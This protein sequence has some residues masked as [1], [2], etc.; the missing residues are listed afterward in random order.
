MDFTSMK[1]DLPGAVLFPDS[2]VGI[3]A[4]PQGVQLLPDAKFSEKPLRLRG[5][6]DHAWIKLRDVYWAGLRLRP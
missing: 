2:H 4:A 3:V 5:E 1:F 6:S